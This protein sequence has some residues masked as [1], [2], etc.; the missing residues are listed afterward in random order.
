MRIWTSLGDVT[1]SA[2]H[3]FSGG[4]LPARRR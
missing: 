2:G 3:P 4:V 1:Y